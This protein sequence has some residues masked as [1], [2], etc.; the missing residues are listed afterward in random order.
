MADEQVQYLGIK[1]SALE[2]LMNRP[3]ILTGWIR[4]V[5]LRH[6]QED[7]IEHPELAR[8]IWRDT[9]RTNILI[10]NH[11]NWTPEIT[12]RRPAIIL[13]RNAFENVR[14]GIA[15]RHTGVGLDGKDQFTTF[16]SGSHTCFCIGETGAQAEVLA[17]EV[18]REL[19]RYADAFRECLGIHRF[20][21]MSVGEASYLEESTENF[22]V[23]VTAGYS[24]EESWIAGPDAPILHKISLSLSSLV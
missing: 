15:D 24:F 12:G 22:V 21:V 16:W 6:F 10:E 5:L 3:Q 1:F 19:T 8:L 23:P 18:R 9:E 2:A 4:D 7:Q 17:E 14:L 13:K 20:K 11:T